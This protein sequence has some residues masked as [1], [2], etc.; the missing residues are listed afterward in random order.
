MA[1]EKHSYRV[2]SSIGGFDTIPTAPDELA[3]FINASRKQIEPWLSAVF[4]AEHL[5]L[6]IGN[7]FT[8]AIAAAAGASGTGMSKVAFGTPFDTA[9][10][11]NA[12]A[13]AKAMG[14]GEANIEDQF[15]SA[16]AVEEGLNVIEPSKAVDVKKAI[17]AQLKTFLDSVLATERGIANTTDNNKKLD[18]EQLLTSF[19]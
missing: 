10:N 17:D 2:G 6:L 3:T 9:I 8:S 18:S 14:R 15:R 13:T 7:G 16:M 19:L 4:Q 11:A 12:D 5:N 1:W